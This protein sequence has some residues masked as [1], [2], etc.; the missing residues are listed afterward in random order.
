MSVKRFC[1]FFLFTGVILLLFAEAY[2][3]GIGETIPIEGIVDSAG[4]NSLYV[5]GKI[6]VAN[7]YSSISTAG[8]NIY[9]GDYV[10]GFIY[11]NEDLPSYTIVSLSKLP[12]KS[13]GTP[14]PLP[15]STPTPVWADLFTATPDPLYT[16]NSGLHLLNDD[17]ETGL[18]AQDSESGT[19]P[20]PSPTPS[21][22]SFEGVISSVKEN[23]LV[24]DGKEYVTDNSTGY[25]AGRNVL[26]EGD[27]VAGRAAPFPGA[28]I[29]R[30]IE[31]VPDY[32]RPDME[33][34]T[35]LGLYQFQ[36]SSKIYR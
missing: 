21:S 17:P 31:I 1:A 13:I 16:Q 27:Y 26:S 3:S 34:R 36:D 23:R 12:E 35:V 18:P 24:I 2:A 6:L 7:E 9:P 5:S 19:V 14:T 29:V 10:M 11:L 28:S 25:K 15:S 30:Y 32:D 33:L 20:A 22:I 4:R 8:S